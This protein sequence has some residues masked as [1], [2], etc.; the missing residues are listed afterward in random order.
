MLN[1]IGDPTARKATTQ[2]VAAMF[3]EKFNCMAVRQIPVERL[4]EAKAGLDGILVEGVK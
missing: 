2:K 4:E 3:R 1:A